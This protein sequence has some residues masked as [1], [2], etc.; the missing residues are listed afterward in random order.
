MAYKGPSPNYEAKL[1]ARLFDDTTLERRRQEQLMQASRRIEARRKE[2]NYQWES[3]ML[4]FDTE[5]ASSDAVSPSIL[6]EQSQTKPENNT[7]TSDAV[8]P[9]ILETNSSSE[10]GMGE[11]AQRNATAVEIR[12]MQDDAQEASATSGDSLPTGNHTKNLHSNSRIATP[13]LGEA[14]AELA[15]PD[16]EVMFQNLRKDILDPLYEACTVD[17]KTNEWIVP[18]E[19]TRLKVD[20]FYWHGALGKAFPHNR[21]IISCTAK[22]FLLECDPNR[23]CKPRLDIVLSF[24]DAPGTRLGK[25]I[26]EPSSSGA[27]QE[28]SS[29][30]SQGRLSVRYHPGAKLIWS[31][32]L[33]PT[34]AMRTRIN[35]ARKKK[36][37]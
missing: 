37:V 1:K 7:D 19:E 14:F 17:I 20:R 16:A 31:D 34:A 32:E 8:R 4:G 29:S 35:S 21:T 25:R 23:N 36:V 22:F 13:S 5:A 11:R 12:M 30:S 24:S 28:P 2:G 9:R 6:G 3:W 18:R 15:D 33:Q 26:Q 10:L 27:I